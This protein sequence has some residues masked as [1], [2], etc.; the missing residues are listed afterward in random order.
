MM[1]T[2][3]VIA[4]VVVVTL[5]YNLTWL[6]DFG[7]AQSISDAEQA[8]INMAMHKKIAIDRQQRAESEHHD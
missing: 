6:L 5:A 3:Y 4:F 2:L 1:E 8:K 7:Y